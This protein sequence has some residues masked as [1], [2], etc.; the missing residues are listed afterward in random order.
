MSLNPTDPD[1]EPTADEHALLPEHAAEAEALRRLTRLFQEHNAPDP[2]P[3]AWDATLQRIE[4]GLAAPKPAPVPKRGSPALRI[5]AGV[6]AAC[7]AALLLAHQFM[8]APG[9]TTPPPIVPADDEEPYAVATADEIVILSMNP[10]NMPSLVVG[11]SPVHG[12]LELA[13]PEDVSLVDTKPNNDGQLP[14]I[15]F[16]GTMPVIVPTATWGDKDKEE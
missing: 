16:G 6:A 2:T 1:K 11:K 5:V 13:G 15:R 14:G 10:A 12:D 8:P 9:K 3:A 7:L 4:S